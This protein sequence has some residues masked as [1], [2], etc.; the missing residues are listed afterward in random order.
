[1]GPSPLGS[2]SLPLSFS[3][4]RAETERLP[5]PAPRRGRYSPLPDAAVPAELL[6]PPLACR[7]PPNLGPAA[8]AHG[9]HNALSQTT[10]RRNA[11][12]VVSQTTLRQATACH[13]NGRWAG[14]CRL[15]PERA[16]HIVAILAQ[17]T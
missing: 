13:P 7:P 5:Q 1:M 17:P 4:G 12:T 10:L 11:A 3:P 9:R 2:R 15:S 14:A 16:R 8:L 6:P